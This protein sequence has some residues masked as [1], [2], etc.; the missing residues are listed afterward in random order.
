MIFIAN[1]LLEIVED[2]IIIRKIV[3][4]YRTV[5][6]KIHNAPSRIVS[7]STSY[8]I[9]AYSSSF[10]LPSPSPA[11]QTTSSLTLLAS[12]FDKHAIATTT[13]PLTFQ[14]LLKKQ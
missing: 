14:Y 11:R 3:E 7:V 10:S 12:T 9:P 13:P 6:T 8:Y 4:I 5:T 2:P 1:F